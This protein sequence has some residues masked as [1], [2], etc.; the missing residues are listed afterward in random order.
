MAWLR[1]EQGL[2][3]ELPAA[4]GPAELR[5]ELAAVIRDVNAHSGRLPTAAVVTAR[6]LTDVLAELLAGPAS[7]P[8]STLTGILTDH[9]PT[10]LKTFLTVENAGAGAAGSLLDQL[11][12]LLDEVISLQEAGRARAADALI[13]QEKFLR[14]KFSNSDLDL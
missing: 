2:G 3:A 9:L 11:E 5:T 4:P 8:A 12:A 1:R 13:T 10:T 7:G 6:E 14:T